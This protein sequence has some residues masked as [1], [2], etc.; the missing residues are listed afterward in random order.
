LLV[1]KTPTFSY[2]SFRLLAG[3]IAAWFAFPFQSC[4]LCYWAVMLLVIGAIAYGVI[5]L[6]STVK[7]AGNQSDW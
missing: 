7:L 6:S 4:S 2:L 5:Y 1:A 3:G